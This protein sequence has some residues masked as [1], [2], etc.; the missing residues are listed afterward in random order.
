MVCSWKKPF[1]EVGDRL[2]GLKV[3][4][5]LDEENKPPHLENPWFIQGYGKNH[6][7]CDIE[8]EDDHVFTKGDDIVS[9]PGVGTFKKECDSKYE[10]CGSGKLRHLKFVKNPLSEH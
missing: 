2:D 7:Y 3:W 6:F 8:D 9:L 4:V 10:R 5:Y 1:V